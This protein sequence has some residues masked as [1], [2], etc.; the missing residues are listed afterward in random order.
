[1]LTL[2]YSLFAFV[3]TGRQR[4][5]SRAIKASA[6]F[7]DFGVRHNRCY[8]RLTLEDSPTGEKEVCRVPLEKA[9]TPAQARDLL[10]EMRVQRRKGRL[11]ILRQAPKFGDF[12]ALYQ[13]FH[14]QAKDTK[15]TSTLATEGCAIKQWKTHLGNVRLDKITRAHFDRCIAPRQGAGISART[16]NLEVTV[17]RNV[18]NKAIDDK[19]LTLTDWAG[20]SESELF[21]P[22]YERSPIGNDAVRRQFSFSF[23][24]PR[25][26]LCAAKAF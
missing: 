8:A 16:V 24:W 15:R 12:C 5:K 13:E 7:A 10:E 6:Q 18:L 9:R 17:L 3:N 2:C 26:F 21:A 4:T 23:G 14:E 19:W 1:M 20:I 25:I 22:R 11:P